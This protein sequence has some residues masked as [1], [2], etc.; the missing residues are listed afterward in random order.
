MSAQGG[1]GAEFTG[2]VGWVVDVIL[3]LG[4][5]GVA[6]MLAL[7]NVLPVVPSEVVLPFAGYLAGQGR[8]SFTLTAVAATVGSTVSAYV[9]Y[10]LG[11]RLGPRRAR[12][13][14]L[15]IP[16][17]DEDDIARATG[18]FERHGSAAVFTGRFVPLVRS[19]ISLP[20]GTQ[21][22]GR[23]RFGLL[24]A[25]GSGI[26]NVVWL[27]VGYLVGKSW[28]SAGRYSDWLNWSLVAFLVLVVGRYVWTR[29][30]RLPWRT[31]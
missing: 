17:T 11:R 18:W 25:L 4:P 6:L 28:H 2:L 8:M 3:A 9:Y 22:M 20:A 16:L 7:D 24:T 26:W 1:A 27:W 14:M 29:R 31:T 12:S 21:G 13:A 19:L 5:V 15:R 30:D 10:E 23:I